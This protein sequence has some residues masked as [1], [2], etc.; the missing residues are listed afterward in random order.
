MVAAG[1]A[2]AAGLD[3]D[4][5]DVGI[6]E[7]RIENA[8]GVGAAA[9][10]GHHVV[11]L[12]SGHLG[13]LHLALLADDRLEVTNHRR[14]GMR[15]RHRADNVERVLD[16]GDP[17]AHGFVERVLQGLRSRFHRHHRR[18]EQLHAIDVLGLAFDVR[19][20][21]V[22][23]ALEAVTGSDRG[24]GDA[25][26]AGAG[27]GNYPRLAHA[28]CQQGLAD[29]VVDLVR[30]GVVQVLALE[31]DLRA[32]NLCRPS[33]CVVDRRGTAHEVL[34]LIVELGHEFRIVTVALIGTAKLVERVNQRLGNEGAAVD[35]E[36]A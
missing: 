28:P 22:D 13:H 9:D 25:V 14:I 15:P 10:A 3:A 36:M 32:A 26:L 8:R 7:V 33:P 20:T 21:H 19:R 18:A 5:L 11:G 4:Q 24:G 12:A 27:L 31:V 29:G 6:V 17:V 23:D 1:D 16:I 35:T 2:F 34:E 30:A